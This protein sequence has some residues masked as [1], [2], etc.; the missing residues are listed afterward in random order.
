MSTKTKT[1]SL[2]AKS[3]L[4]ITGL[5][6][7]AAS[8]SG[9]SSAGAA[10]GLQGAYFSGNGQ[11]SN[12]VIIT[13]NQAKF[14]DVGQKCQARPLF[15]LQVSKDGTEMYDESDIYSVDLSA[16]RDRFTLMGTRYVS[17]DNTDVKRMLQKWKQECGSD[18]ELK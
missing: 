8:L 18:L 6:L 3:L 17:A 16:D 10:G 11:V 7:A 2:L 5:A 12:G 4:G 9:C 14:F 13:G 15:H 1:K